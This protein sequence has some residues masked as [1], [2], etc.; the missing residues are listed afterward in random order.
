MWKFASILLLIILIGCG[1]T[2]ST[3][4]NP[5]EETAN[6]KEKVIQQVEENLSHGYQDSNKV[7]DQT[8]TTTSPIIKDPEYGILPETIKIDSIEVESAVEHVGLMK[9]GQMAVPENFRITGWYDKGPKPGERGSAVI[10]GHVD[11]KTGPGVFFD[12]EDLQKG[13]KIEVLNDKGKKLV[14]KVV[15]KETF[16]MNDAPI[17]D[18]F[19]YTPRRMLNLV[20]CTGPFKRSKGGHIDRLVVYTELQTEE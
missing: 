19:G 10:A 14:F 12:L 2:Q 9:N 4:S 5:G 18:I 20:T 11:D 15:D 16:P 17:K 13:D 1:Q 7:S 3:N 8:E 6:A